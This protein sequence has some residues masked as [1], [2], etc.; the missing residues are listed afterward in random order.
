MNRKGSWDPLRQ[1]PWRLNPP[2]EQIPKQLA[3]QGSAEPVEVPHSSVAVKL[4]TGIVFLREPCPGYTWWLRLPAPL[5]HAIKKKPKKHSHVAFA[6]A[7]SE[8]VY[9]L[10]PIESKKDLRQNSCS[11]ILYNSWRTFLEREG[12]Y[13]LWQLL[14]TYAWKNCT[15]LRF[16]GLPCLQSTSPG[17]S[18]R[19]PDLCLEMARGIGSRSLNLS[20]GQPWRLLALPGSAGGDAAAPEL[21]AAQHSQ[22]QDGPCD[23]PMCPQHPPP[24]ASLPTCTSSPP[25]AAVI[26]SLT[27]ALE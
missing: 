12:L 8:R 21:I 1:Q 27:V 25:V 20:P 14:Y 9:T 4:F 22:R 2:K 17:G 5:V 10:P 6:R 19:P 11:R 15:H 24:R 23:A 13:L 18:W 3:L 26:N 16:P 7:E